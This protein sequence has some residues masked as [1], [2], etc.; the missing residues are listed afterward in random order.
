MFWI[1]CLKILKNAYHNLPQ[2]KVMHCLF[3]LKAQ[4]HSF[5]Y[6]LLLNIYSL[7]FTLIL[8]KL[9]FIVVKLYVCFRWHPCFCTVWC[10]QCS[11]S[12]SSFVI[13]R[14]QN[15]SYIHHIYPWGNSHVC[16][17]IW[18]KMKL[19]WKESYFYP[20]SILKLDM[21]MIVQRESVNMSNSHLLNTQLQGG[22]SHL[23]RHDNSHT[24]SCWKSSKLVMGVSL[25]KGENWVKTILTLYHVASESVIKVSRKK[26]NSKDI[27]YK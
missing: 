12:S 2:V 6:N 23:C 14:R 21:M 19:H 24:C 10:V 27:S 1:D 9:K 4:R 15:R 8:L 18:S 7:K 13:V 20:L 11:I 22:L 26:S 16:T 3:F 17:L 25:S 5:I